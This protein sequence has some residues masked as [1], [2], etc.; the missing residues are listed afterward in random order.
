MRTIFIMLIA[1]RGT[2]GTPPPTSNSDTL[3]LVRNTT[4]L[5]LTVK[6]K[7]PS[8]GFVGTP[9]WFLPEASQSLQQRK[10]LLTLAAS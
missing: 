5:L 7:L 9:T 1:C 3:S 8:F 2:P 6:I 4:G 10:D